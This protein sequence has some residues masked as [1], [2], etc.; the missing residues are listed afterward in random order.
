[1]RI[2][3]I[4]T[5]SIELEEGWKSKVGAA[6][7]AGLGL[8]GAGEHASAQVQSYQNPPVAT[9]QQRQVSRVNAQGQPTDHV[10]YMQRVLGYARPY[11]D[12]GLLSPEENKIYAKY[13]NAAS[14]IYKKM[15]P[16]WQ[17]EADKNY[18]SG[19]NS[20]KG[21]MRGTS[22]QILRM[23]ATNALKQ[24]IAQDIKFGGGEGFGNFGV[25]L[26][27]EAKSFYYK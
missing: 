17:Q 10:R 24:V 20:A 14:D 13:A 1:M 26:N 4:I 11:H 16:K 8:L 7:L 12:A 21:S 6:A 15:A 23:Q 18:S 3:E 9:A 25:M 5:E 22:Q 19:F 2:N 27:P